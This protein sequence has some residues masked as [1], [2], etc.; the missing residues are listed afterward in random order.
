[1]KTKLGL[2]EILFWFACVEAMLDSCF[3]KLLAFGLTLLWSSSSNV[4]HEIVKKE[5]KL[6]WDWRLFHVGNPLGCMFDNTRRAADSLSS[7]YLSCINLR[8]YGTQTDRY[9]L[10][11][12]GHSH[13]NT[14][15][16]AVLSGSKLEFFSFLP[17]IFSRYIYSMLL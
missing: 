15:H 11:R 1:M 14:V 12:R 5:W 6:M 17:W 2:S 4:R 16:S 8:Q 10:Y 9:L 7:H 13:V 3:S